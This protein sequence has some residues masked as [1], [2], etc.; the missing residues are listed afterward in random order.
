M[1][2]FAV[3]IER[4]AING[5]GS[6]GQPLGILNTTGIGNVAMGTNGG[7]PTLAKI[8]ELVQVVEDANAGMNGKFAINPKTASALK[9]TPIET[10]SGAKIMAYG[11]YFGGMQD[12]IDSKYVAK[13]TIIPSN[14]TK[15]NSNGICSAMI[16]GDWENLVIG[17][18]GGIDITIDNMSQAIGGKN[19][20]VMNQYIGIAVK[21]PAAFGAILDLLT[22]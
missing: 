3:E 17:Q 12:Q 8:L 20:V 19:R 4:A 1:K 5:S 2:S 14:L 21:R 18:Y 15:G 22:A 10:G 7:L 6:N 13:S 16:Y 11:P 9:Q